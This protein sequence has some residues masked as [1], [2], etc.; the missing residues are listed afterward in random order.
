M[1]ENIFYIDLSDIKNL[2]R[3]WLKEIVFSFAKA[4]TDGTKDENKQNKQN[5][6]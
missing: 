2:V 4:N 1:E 5:F 3:K 6:N